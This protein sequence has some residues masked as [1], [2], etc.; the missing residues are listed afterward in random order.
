[1]IF[2][3]KF[4]IAY[5]IIC[6]DFVVFKRDMRH[7]DDMDIEICVLRQVIVSDCRLSS[8]KYILIARIPI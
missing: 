1:M 8:V 3:R 2:F 6:R 5:T 7:Y 4:F